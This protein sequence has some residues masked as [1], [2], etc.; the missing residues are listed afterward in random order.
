MRTTWVIFICVVPTKNIY[1]FSELLHNR[2][3]AKFNSCDFSCTVL[4]CFTCLWFW[5]ISSVLIHVA[6]ILVDLNAAIL[7]VHY[8]VTEYDNDTPHT[9][10]WL[11]ECACLPPLAGGYQVLALPPALSVCVIGYL[12]TWVLFSLVC[13]CVC[14]YCHHHTR[15]RSHPVTQDVRQRFWN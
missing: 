11:C 8:W 6:L 4:H 7:L 5:H 2:P 3:L 9:R 1:S 10:Q 13:E 15:A 14:V 12:C